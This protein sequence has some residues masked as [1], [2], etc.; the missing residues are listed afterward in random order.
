MTL[1]AFALKIQSYLAEFFTLIIFELLVK[2][3]I[4]L[5]HLYYYYYYYYY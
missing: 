3:K 4:L 5:C 2:G 1:K